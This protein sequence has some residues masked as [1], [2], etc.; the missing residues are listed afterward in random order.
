MIKDLRQTA[1]KPIV[2]FK[3]GG[4]LL[5]QPG[6]AASLRA[7]RRLRP[8]LDTLLIVGGGEA[9]D[10]VRRW[11]AAHS[12]TDEQAHW[13]AIEAMGLNELL[14]QQLLPELRPV[15]NSKQLAAA[16]CDGMWPLLCAGCF[17]RWAESAGAKPLPRTWDVTSDSIAA[18]I[19]R[20][21]AA[22][23]LVLVKSC[24]LNPKLSVTEAAAQGLVDSHF[25]SLAH[26]LETISWSNLCAETISVEPWLQ[27]GKPKSGN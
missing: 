13:L 25:P 3:F 2:V 14:L 9:A 12:L 16:W 11:D 15:R 23:E 7:L 27:L 24:S 18:W 22:Q 6:V 5:C 10:V 1:E 8:D 26:T 20:I 19:T 4:S 21:A 17:I